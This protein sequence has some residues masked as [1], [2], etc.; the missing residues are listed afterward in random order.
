M[1]QRV[2]VTGTGIISALGDTPEQVHRAL[3][4]G[5]TALK[6]VQLFDTRGTHCR[7]GG[8]IA[9]FAAEKYLGDVNLRPLDRTCQLVVCAAQRA[10]QS[11]GWTADGLREHSVG[12][13]LG[14]MFCSVHT[15]AE[16][17]RRGLT[18]GPNYV[19]PL[20]FANTVINAAAGQAAIWHDLR[21]INST[22]AS[23]LSSGLQAI[24]YGADMIRSGRATALLA[25]GGDEMC[26]E[27]FFGFDRAGLLCGSAAEAE[28]EFPLPYDARRNG[29]A[30][31]EGAAFLVLEE[32][33]A[34]MDRGA[35]IIGEVC[36]HGRRFDPAGGGDGAVESVAQSVLASLA[37][38]RL[39][40]EAIDAVSA[41]ANGSPEGDRNEAAALEA[42]FGVD[43]VAR[44]PVTAP[45]ALLGETLGAGGAVQTVAA[46][47][48]MAAGQLP[49]THGLEQVEEGFPLKAVDAEVRSLNLRRIAIN[50]SGHDGHSC[51][52]IIAAPEAQGD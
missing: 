30:V 25:G 50:S 19:R 10:L 31:G 51:A 23:G 49:G 3:C 40:P 9:D 8:E 7:Q 28:A 39:G 41:G 52:L 47:A 21:G 5:I 11:S 17:D 35:R 26:Y 29:F 15:I 22:V 24:A 4:C 42:V 6:P 20:D 34:A 13:V 32:E 38:A 27:S 14:T 33:G 43:R 48:A 12:M 16:F 1:K 44:L 37:D 2:V 45:K 46:L 36:G 18:E